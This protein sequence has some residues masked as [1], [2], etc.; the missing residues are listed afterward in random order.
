MSL[1]AELKRRNVFRVGLAYLAGSWLL[2]EGSTV[3]LEAFG[4]PGWVPKGLAAVLALGF[5]IALFFAWAFELTPEGVKREADV[6]R[7]RSITAHT[8]K[9][10]DL[11]TIVLVV[12]VG[13][14]V[15]VDRFVLD[16]RDANPTEVETVSAPDEEESAG[17]PAEKGP[18]ELSI[19]VLPFVNMSPD[20][21]NEYFADGLSEELLNVLAQ[22]QDFKVTG[23]T[24][25]FAF[26]GEDLDLR[27]VGA[28]LDVANI[29][30]G[31]VRKAGDQVRV[32]AQL[33]KVSDG[34]HLWSASYD[35]ELTNIFAIQ[36]DIATHVVAA[37]KSTLLGDDLAVIER[38]GTDNIDAYQHLLR[39][40]RLITTRQRDDLERGI[41]EL[42]RAVTL[43]PSYPLAHAT[44]AEALSHWITYGFATD[45]D[46]IT[47]EISDHAEQ[48]LSI[49]PS[50][51]EAYTARWFAL[52]RTD[53]PVDD[54]RAVLQRAIELNPNYALAHMWLAGLSDDVEFAYRHT[55]RAYELDPLHPVI[56]SNLIQRAGWLGR[57][58]EA[59]RLLEELESLDPDW[60]GLE[61]ARGFLAAGSADFGSFLRGFSDALEKDP[62]DLNSMEML[63][64]QY[65]E[66]GDLAKARSVIDRGLALN[67]N[68]DGLNR[69]LAN[70]HWRSGET[71]AAR[72]LLNSSPQG[73]WVDLILH[74]DGPE[75]AVE[76]CLEMYGLD[77]L[78][79]S[80]DGWPIENVGTVALGDWGA[81]CILA[82]RNSG[83]EEAADQ[84][85]KAELAVLSSGGN[86]PRLVMVSLLANVHG[87]MGNR[88]AWL[89]EARWLADAGWP[90]WR[91]EPRTS[92]EINEVWMDAYDQDADVRAV[93]DQ[94]H[95][96]AIK[97]RKSLAED[98]LATLPSDVN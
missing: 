78:P 89:E 8:G 62:Q 74:L 82:L 83:L 84:L 36:D 93:V 72:E 71:G 79:D 55:R 26:K 40:R 37:L 25:S 52:Q 31:S 63:A 39:G 64:Y 13:A 88:D 57:T 20:A 9:R 95:A 3:A 1:F 17:E 91:F 80:V 18:S 69:A 21:D 12:A 35:R 61:R 11:I 28:R 22:I 30:E 96:N 15:V 53:A 34:Y 87:A 65:L 32:T 46:A 44:L 94:F 58:A 98:G 27:E 81:H 56:L 67:P 70:L 43:D 45:S 7:S 73:H 59:E 76:A 85:A 66:V 86:W 48:A 38:E 41:A 19:A 29:L 5:P 68:H 33:V 2:I 51:P 75:S 42:R 16:S 14:L 54:A 6:D 49:D 4:A 77:A 50:L 97:A 10:L 23:R 92:L 90:R 47:G 24:S 60:P